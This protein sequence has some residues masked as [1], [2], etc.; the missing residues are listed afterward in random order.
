MKKS[1]YFLFVALLFFISTKKA[2]SQIDSVRF[3]NGQLIVGEIK[4]MDKGVLEIETDYS[5]SDFLIEWKKVIWIKTESHFQIST[6]DGL[7]Y[8]ST[9][10]SLN[11]SVALIVA[12]DNSLLSLWAQEDTSE[13]TVI[14]IEIQ[15]IV[16]LNAFDDKFKDRLSASIDVGLDLAKAKNL[17]TFTTRSSIG[18][19]A[20]LVQ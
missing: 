7:Q 8:Y 20:Y 6:V 5:D 13:A 11:D 14:S 16:Y 9:V 4:T 12:G 15:E 19:K 18:Y 17:R 3:S 10:K 2:S 1:F